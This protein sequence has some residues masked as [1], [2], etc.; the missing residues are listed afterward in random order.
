MCSRVLVLYFLFLLYLYHLFELT[1]VIFFKWPLVLPSFL[2]CRLFLDRVFFAWFFVDW[3]NKHVDCLGLSWR[4]GTINTRPM[5]WDWISFDL[6]S[7][8]FFGRMSHTTAETNSFSSDS[9]SSVW[10]PP[11]SCI[12]IFW[13]M[14]KS[15]SIVLFIDP[16]Y[17][18]LVRIS[19]NKWL[20]N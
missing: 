16:D 6:P 7:S 20:V 15:S 2:G 10:K 5:G 19:Y 3:E 13:I 1:P 11:Y 14:Y 8:H 18:Q 9:L 17:L 12:S 4:C